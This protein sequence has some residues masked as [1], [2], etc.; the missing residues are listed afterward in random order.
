MECVWRTHPWGQNPLTPESRVNTGL[1][2]GPAVASVVPAMSTTTARSDAPGHP[3]T[4][5]ARLD[6]R[7]APPRHL[8]QG[9]AIAPGQRRDH[10]PPSLARALRVADAVRVR[11]AKAAD[12]EAIALLFQEAY[13]LSSH[14]CQKAEN[15]RD[16]M[17][18]GD[19]WFVAFVGETLGACTALLR[20]P[21]LDAYE[22]GRAVTRASL[23]QSGVGSTLHDEVGALITSVCDTALILGHPRNVPCLTLVTRAIAPSPS[24]VVGTDGGLNVANGVREHHLVWMARGPRPVRRVRPP[25]APEDDPVL[26]RNVIAALELEGVEGTYPDLLMIGPRTGSSHRVGRTTFWVEHDLDSPGRSVTITG[27]QPDGDVASCLADLEE[28]LA[29]FPAALHVG[30]TILAHQREA[31]GKL[32]A[33][34]FRTAAYLPALYPQDGRRY[35]ALTMC[36]TSFAEPPVYIGTEAIAAELAPALDAYGR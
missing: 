32:R 31:M 3:L 2:D 16:S 33:A 1:S 13:G 9:P 36:R 12:A 20:I 24:A 19:L 35:D 18:R 14:V 11:P 4:T 8:H 29:L 34:G 25:V 28:L 6:G 15:V 10:R 26:A 7:Q 21:W 30:V 17:K 23:R 5:S 27:A 22:W